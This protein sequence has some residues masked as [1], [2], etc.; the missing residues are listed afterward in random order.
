VLRASGHQVSANALLPNYF[1]GMFLNLVLPGSFGGDVYRVV[2]LS[3]RIHDSEIAFA[4][5]LLERFTGLVAMLGVGILGLPVL[6][7]MI[8]RWDIIL[9]FVACT[10]MVFTGVVLTTSPRLLK[11][12]APL[13]ERLKLRS[14]VERMAKLQWILSKFAHDRRSLVLAIG[15]SL[16][17]NLAI[18]YYQYLI[19]QQLQIPISY[20]ALL[21]FTPI[22]VIVTL[23]PISFGGLGLNESLRAYLFSRAGLTI[24]QAVLLSLMYTAFGWI[25]GLPGSLILLSNFATAKFKRSH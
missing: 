15:L 21:V 2:R 16:I 6:F 20:L 13:L 11:L 3:R 10:G 4:S 17:I 22:L 25:L 12:T 14:F 23:L 1:A 5:V 7:N 18:I 8:E 24:D 19:A 9:L